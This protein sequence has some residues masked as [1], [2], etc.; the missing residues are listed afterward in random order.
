[1]TLAGISHA[2]RYFPDDPLRK[3]VPPVHIRDA[4]YRATSDILDG[5]ANLFAKPGERHPE[6]VVIPAMG[7]N[8]LG[9][10]LEGAWYVPRH[11]RKRMTAEEL[12]RGPNKGG[13]PLR[14]KPWQVLMVKRYDVRP[15]L[16]I[17]D[18]RNQPYLIRVDVLN[19]PEMST[20]A[21]MVVANIYHALGYWVP[22]N[23]IVE[24]LRSDLKA[25]PDGKDINAVGES[26]KLM[27]E[28]IDL[29]L[30]R[31]RAEKGGQYRVVATK[32]PAGK[33]LGPIS[34]TGTRSDDP[35]DLFPHEHRRE[36][37]ALS[38]LAGWL[39]QN[40]ISSSATLDFLVEENG[41]NHVRHYFADFFASLGSG[42]LRAKEARE[43]S[44]LLFDWN[45]G[46]R[47]FLGFSIY[48]PS[49][50]R[51]KFSRA[52]GTGRFEYENF[53]PR[54]WV[55]NIYLP[56]ISNAL[57]DDRYWAAK[58]VMA[59]ND[60]DIRALVKAGQYS[61]PRAADWL[62]ECLVRRRDKIGKAF[63]T[64]VLPLDEFK[65]EDG[66]VKFQHLGASY[67][68]TPEPAYT[69]QWAI[70]NNFTG[71][72]TPLQA[73]DLRVPRAVTD[74]AGGTYFVVRLSAGEY[75][76][77]VDVFIRSEASGAKI[78]G[79]ER[80][81]PGKR[82]AQN[83]VRGEKTRRRY[84]DLE[85]DR[86]KLFDDFTREYN[87]KTQFSVTPEDYFESLSISERTTFDAVTHALMKTR[88]ND[89][90]GTSL[91]TALDLVTGI[92]RI[93]GHQ[94]GRHGDEQ[95]RIYVRL[96]RD[97]RAILEKSRQF[98]L[99]RENTI[100]HIGYPFDFRQTGK[101]PTLQMSL[102][103]DGTRADI[104]VDYRSS[105]LPEAIWNGHLSSANS[106]IRAG[107]NHE[108]HSGRWEGLVNWWRRTYG[109]LEHVSDVPEG[110]IL[111]VQV[112][113]EVITPLP[114]NRPMGTSLPELADAA[115]EFLADW[116][117]RHKYDEAMEF[118]SDECL[119]CLVLSPGSTLTN[120][121]RAAM[122]GIL[123]QVGDRMGEHSS[124]STVISAANASGPNIRQ[125]N[126]QHS[127]DF[128]LVEVT[129]AV[130]TSVL[131]RNRKGRLQKGQPTEPAFG[132]YYVTLFK[133]R[134]P[135]ASEG[136]LALLWKTESGRWRI[137]SYDIVSN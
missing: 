123:E 114:P 17:A 135:M 119:P 40:W 33:A 79:V 52:R 109:D 42:W 56:P 134:I 21:T 3:E 117:V 118:I 6:S 43:G 19:E 25:S 73:N 2:Q 30:A 128:D 105:K 92:E 93:A 66:L 35:N 76:K 130:G 133:F 125:L 69:A 104:D 72:R 51:S 97:A 91:G 81:W 12:T 9:E 4:N 115:Q 78:V 124:L 129:D 71:D 84:A 62:S 32:V 11:I 83:V 29:F 46:F 57:P 18:S 8:T 106:D 95:F 100:Y 122:R 94:Y 41:I 96:R 53:D 88:L 22:E 126:H 65:I 116:L 80:H 60:D 121:T 64:D 102:S 89:Q 55:P 59:F 90:S 39:G 45:R 26:T 47:N 132:N 87:N 48:S 13:P 58:Q 38:V 37:R 85:R 108:R 70:F 34:F 75:S 110:E 101:F 63:F 15:G 107:N 7:V 31:A 68:F 120:G 1:L 67:G 27:E 10:P 82:V 137:Q 20:G 54:L 86:K 131:C 74:S 103:E 5:A 50:Q 28:D 136:T 98:Y 49:W 44:E 99:S 77:H 112:P 14:D 111:A 24:I 61:D 36:L 113:P 127:R 16:L 23:Y